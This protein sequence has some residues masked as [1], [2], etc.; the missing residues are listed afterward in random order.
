MGR[1]CSCAGCR[2][3]SCGECTNCKGQKRFGGDGRSHQRCIHRICTKVSRPRT[4]EPSKPEPP[5]I[6]GKRTRSAP[7]VLKASAPEDS[8]PVR[9]KPK[10][11]RAVTESGNGTTKRQRCKTCP[12]CFA[13]DCGDCNPCK[14]KPKVR[15]R[16]L[17]KHVFAHLLAVWWT[18]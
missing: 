14:D 2:R 13:S 15:I 5:A 7:P 1:R 4:V 6:L 12:A 18:R 17:C 9:S 8:P 3:S 16:L 10:R 11:V